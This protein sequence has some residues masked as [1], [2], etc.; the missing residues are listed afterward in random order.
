MFKNMVMTFLLVVIGVLIGY[1][2]PLMKVNKE[3]QPNIMMLE[4]NVEA[5]NEIVVKELSGIL[6]KKLESAFVIKSDMGETFYVPLNE[7]AV[8]KGRV[9]G[10]WF[11]SNDLNKPLFVIIP[12]E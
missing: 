3:V 6:G 1:N 2:L 8:I 7:S 12:G 9:M 11:M 10:V 4:Q 5:A